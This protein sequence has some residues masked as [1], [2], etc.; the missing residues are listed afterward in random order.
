MSIFLIKK[1]ELKLKD[2]YGYEIV[3]VMKIH[4]KNISKLIDE[5]CK[6]IFPDYLT[7]D[8]EGIEIDILKN[9]NFTKNYPKVIVCET[10]S[11]SE[12]GN[13]VKIMIS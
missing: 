6:G 10:I 4:T 13:G 2:D 9:I 3:K 11:Y 5:Y 8:V 1:Q 12:N 7:I